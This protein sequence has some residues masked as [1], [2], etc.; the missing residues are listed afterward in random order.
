MEDSLTAIYRLQRDDHNR[1]G[2]SEIAATH[3]VTSKSGRLLGDA[4][5]RCDSVRTESLIYGDT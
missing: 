4:P 3:G 5:A 1:V 2:P